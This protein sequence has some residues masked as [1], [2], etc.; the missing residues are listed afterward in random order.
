MLVLTDLTA[1][2]SMACMLER[3]RKRLELI[4]SAVTDGGNFF[5]AIESY[6]A[7]LNDGLP[8]MLAHEGPPEAVA[9]E[10]YRAIHT[11]KGLLNQFSFATSPVA[12]HDVESSLADLLNEPGLAIARIAQAIPLQTLHACLAQD[13]AILSDALDRKS[14]V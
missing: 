1:E 14:V 7:L 10:V 6:R 12:L 2:R 13:L 4:V 3:E 8:G 9:G 5:D 11:F